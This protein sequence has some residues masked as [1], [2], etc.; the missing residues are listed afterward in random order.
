MI[1]Y[2]YWILGF[3][4]MDY[5][6]KN[7]TARM[8]NRKKMRGRRK[9]KEGREGGRTQRRE[10]RRKTWTR[11]RIHR[12]KK[13]KGDSRGWISLQMHDTH[14]QTHPNKLISMNNWY[15]LILRRENWKHTGA[16]H[17]MPYLCVPKLRS[18]FLLL[19][20]SPHLSN[21]RRLHKPVVHI[22]I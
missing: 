7:T 3:S 1:S 15:V 20:W 19:N 8:E 4:N 5:L 6:L 2:I 13:G 12:S 21:Y 18:Y 22:N 9:W 16:H 11:K 14:A 17:D 10:G